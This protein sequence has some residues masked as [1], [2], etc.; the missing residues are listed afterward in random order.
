[1]GSKANRAHWYHLA[2]VEVGIWPLHWLSEV[3]ATQCQPCFFSFFPHGRLCRISCTR[4]W[5]TVIPRLV[6]C[7]LISWWNSTGKMSGKTFNWLGWTCLYWLRIIVFARHEYEY[8]YSNSTVVV[9][10]LFMSTS[11]NTDTS[12]STSTS[13]TRVRVWV[14]QLY[15]CSQVLIHE[16]EYEH[17]HEY[18]YEYSNSTVVVKYLFMSTSMSTPTLQL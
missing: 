8:E 11:I 9:K 17:R 10:Y 6:R 12:T 14:L 7:P 3:H 16:Y 5:V 15:S 13:M 1:M 18:E 2:T 4:C